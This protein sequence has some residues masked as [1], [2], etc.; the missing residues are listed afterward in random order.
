[1][2]SKMLH[3]IIFVKDLQIPAA[4]E[5]VQG[6]VELACQGDYPPTGKVLAGF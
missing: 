4:V 6:L 1:M 5:L 3:V 2:D